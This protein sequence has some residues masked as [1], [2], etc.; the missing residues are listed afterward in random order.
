M[1]SKKPRLLSLKG[2]WV[3]LPS[4]HDFEMFLSWLHT[5]NKLD[6]SFEFISISCL[7]FIA[8]SDF[9][10]CV[11]EKIFDMLFMSVHE[12]LSAGSQR[13]C[14]HSPLMTL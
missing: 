9:V 7:W 12:S 8:Q 1:V 3:H 4:L 10:L 2:L 13:A 11:R 6:I 5:E 14:T